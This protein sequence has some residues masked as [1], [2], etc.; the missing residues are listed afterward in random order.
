GIESVLPLIGNINCALIGEPTEMHPAVAEKGLMVVDAVVHGK[1]GHA[2]LDE[3]ENAIY[4][5]LPVIEWFRNKR[6]L[7]ADALSGEV[8]MTVT[9][10]EAGSQ[11]NVVPCECRFSVDVRTNKYYTNEEVFNEI[12]S[13][14]NCEVKARSFRLRSS[15]ISMK[16]PLVDRILM[17]GGKPFVSPTLSDQCLVPFPSL[18]LGPGSSVRSHIADE[19]VHVWE[20]REAISIYF[21]LLNKLSLR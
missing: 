4:K 13:Q 15:F 8:K 2:A 6:F 21:K 10:L 19:F 20:I 1:S 18:K 17:L 7:K 5:A 12:A 11:H 14:C 9:M 16:H 3:G